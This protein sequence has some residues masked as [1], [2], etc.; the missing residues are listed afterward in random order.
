VVRLSLVPLLLSACMVDAPIVEANDDENELGVD[1][2]SWCDTFCERSEECGL[3]TAAPCLGECVTL[4]EEFAGGGVTC[5]EAGQRA[6]AC[7][8]RASCAELAGD[9]P[10][11]IRDEHAR[12]L[13]S[14]EGTACKAVDTSGSGHP[15][16][17]HHFADCPNG[18][19]YSLECFADG[20][21]SRCVCTTDGVDEG[22]FAA[23]ACPPA[24]EA[25]RICAWPIEREDGAPVAR[26]ERCVGGGSTGPASVDC[27]MDFD[28]CSDGH[29][30][31]VNCTA[32]ERAVRCECEIDGVV[33]RVYSSPAGICEF[34]A[35]DPYDGRVALNYACGFAI[36]AG[37]PTAD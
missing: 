28:Q 36:E 31:G 22:E 35:S 16:C 30:Y 1:I 20:N 8:E 18:R 14:A 27:I 3:E 11:S 32:V 25:I 24:D 34:F 5:A 9:D 37:A 6:I 13:D 10:C 15:D 7:L 17:G 4:L 2:G 29:S 23:V 21:G 12:C 19:Q 26:A 33:V